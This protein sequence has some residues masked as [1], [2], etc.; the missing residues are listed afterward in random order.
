M[1]LTSDLDSEVDHGGKTQS[2]EETFDEAQRRGEE[3]HEA[4]IDEAPESWRSEK[5]HEEA[6]EKAAREEGDVGLLS[7]ALMLRR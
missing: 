5:S 3:S 7:T 2:E 6:P 1:F 4:Q